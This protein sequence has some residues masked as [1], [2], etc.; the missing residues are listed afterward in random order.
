M[1]NICS[2]IYTH[3]LSSYV[4]ANYL[5]FVLRAVKMANGCPAYLVCPSFVCL[6]LRFEIRKLFIR[7]FLHDFWFCENYLKFCW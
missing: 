3:I 1:H 4:F 6:V 2:F 5:K 7:K